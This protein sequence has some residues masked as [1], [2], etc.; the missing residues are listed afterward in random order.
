LLYQQAL[1]FHAKKLLFQKGPEVHIPV[2][3]LLASAPLT[4]ITYELTRPFG[5]TPLQ[6]TDIIQLLTSES[7]RYV[8]SPTHRII[9]NRKWLIISPNT[10]AIASNILIEE[11]DRMIEF[12]GDSKLSIEIIQ[13]SIPLSD[14]P[15]DQNIACLAASDIKFPLL[16]RKWKQGDYFYP[17]GMQKK[18]KLSRFFIDQKL[19]MLQKEN[20]WV[21]EMNNKIIWVVGKRIDNR[22][23][24]SDKTASILRF[25]LS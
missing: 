4:T 5:F 18:K 13:H 24:V 11:N 1:S 19:S 25:T 21:I 9:R 2:L 20:S 6:T 7:G 12:N 10:S 3:K 17:L 16:L 15:A 22:F 23:K 14:L 8:Q